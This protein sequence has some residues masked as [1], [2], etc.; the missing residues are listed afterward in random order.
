MEIV[1][2]LLASGGRAAESRILA[3]SS[4]FTGTTAPTRVNEIGVVETKIYF[5]ARSSANMFKVRDFI[6][7]AQGVL[8]SVVSYSH[9]PFGILSYPRAGRTGA[10]KLKFSRSADG[11]RFIQSHYPYFL[12]RVPILDTALCVVPK[13]SVI[14]HYT[15]GVFLET[16]LGQGKP[17]IIVELAQALSSASGLSTDDMG[18]TG[19]YLVGLQTSSSDV[20]VVIY[21][22][23]NYPRAKGGVKKGIA[24]GTFEELSKEDW[25]TIYRKRGINPSD[26][27]FPEFLRH[28]L[29]K[30]NR[31]KFRGH[32][33]DVLSCRSDWEIEE[34]FGHE[35]YS[36]VGEATLK[37]KVVDAH[38]SG[39]Y[40]ATYEVRGRAMGLKI[41]A[42]VSYTHTY[43]DQVFDGE[44]ALC[45]GIV[46]RVCDRRCYY[47]LLIGSTREAPNQFIKS[48]N[49]MQDEL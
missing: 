8:F 11:L 48:L 3:L 19:S 33:F 5:S 14:R 35:T 37:C 26:Y 43:V 13:Y 7:T 12:S 17:R 45:R 24:D 28:E 44:L 31:A 16:A 15:P 38:L 2:L 10:D 36:R 30:H 49:L 25:I 1:S 20:D 32:T 29:R 39:D 22:L 21:G 42:V 40:P 9:P 41:E 34:G 18:I 4:L 6:E 46:E 23:A 27:S 47:R